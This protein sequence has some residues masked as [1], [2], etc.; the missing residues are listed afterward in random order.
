MLNKKITE[1]H[2]KDLCTKGKTSVIKGMKSKAGKTFDA[3]L[4]LKDGSITFEFAKSKK[5]ALNLKR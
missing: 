5:V 3:S 4:I 1:K 2:V